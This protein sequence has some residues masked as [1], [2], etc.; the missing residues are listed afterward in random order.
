MKQ[1][2]ENLLQL[3]VQMGIWWGGVL[4]ET[5]TEGRGQINGEKQFL[6]EGNGT[7]RRESSGTHTQEAEGTQGG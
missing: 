5:S 3:T 6:R 7:H 4:R 2:S 1:K